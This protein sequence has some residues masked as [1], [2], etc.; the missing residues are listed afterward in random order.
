MYSP[1]SLRKLDGHLEVFSN[2]YKN[3]FW[4]TIYVRSWESDRIFY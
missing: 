4:T 3:I 2:I 1:H